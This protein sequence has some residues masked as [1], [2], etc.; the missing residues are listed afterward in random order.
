MEEEDGEFSFRG[1]VQEDGVI[2][3]RMEAARDTSVGWLLDAQALGREGNATIWA[4]T[5]LGANTPDVRPPG[6]VRRRA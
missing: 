6:A 5:G 4:D 1:R 3:I 2:A